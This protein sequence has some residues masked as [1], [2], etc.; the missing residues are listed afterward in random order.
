MSNLIRKIQKRKRGVS[1]RG[2]N[3]RGEPN[4]PAMIR[5]SK[6]VY[7]SGGAARNTGNHA[8]RVA[9]LV[10]WHQRGEHTKAVRGCPNCPAA[11][12]S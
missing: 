2:L 9:S 7:Q 5:G 8:G 4:G 10:R 12:K 11:V 6:R 3:T 1:R